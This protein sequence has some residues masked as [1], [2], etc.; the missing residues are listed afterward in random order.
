M[1]QNR[2]RF[3]HSLSPKYANTQ[4]LHREVT[5]QGYTGSRVTVW[6]Y[7]Y[8][9]RKADAAAKGMPS[10]APRIEPPRQQIPKAQESVWLLLKAEVQLTAAEKQQREQLLQI[11]TVKRSWELVQKFRQFLAG[12]KRAELEQWMQQAEE[13][14][15]APFKGFLSGVRRDLAAVQN[16]FSLPWS[17]GQTEGQVNRLKFLKRQMFGR[18]K[19]DLLRA[20]VLHYP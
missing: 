8:P 16:A 12:R 17:N 13:T 11:P 14:E 5:A 6:R 4:Q 20:R 19:F 15:G 3:T 9:W 2:C 10:T 7:L 1:P 18:A